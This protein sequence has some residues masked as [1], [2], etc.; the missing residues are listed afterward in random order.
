MRRTLP[1]ADSTVSESAVVAAGPQVPPPNPFTL[2]SGRPRGSPEPGVLPGD[3]IALRNQQPVVPVAGVTADKLIDSFDDLR[4]GT[5]RHNALDIMAPRN[6]PVVAATAGK[7]LKLHN[8][9][10]GGLTVYASDPT[11]RY[12]FLY[13]HLETFRTGLAEG[14]LVRRG[15]I[16]GFVGSSGNASLL[17][18]HLHFAI[19]RNDDMRSWWKGNP[20]NPFLIY[21]GR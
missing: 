14:A 3:V 19:T 21:R 6:T 8:S 4:G 5:R 20:L 2:P 13:G 9:V 15:E 10:A 11:E 1:G 16:I 7:I 18:P 17:A 12:V